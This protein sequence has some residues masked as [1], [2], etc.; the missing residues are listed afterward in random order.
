[1]KEKKRIKERLEEIK[2]ETDKQKIKK[3][4]FINKK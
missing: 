4:D 3:F 1:V 2:F